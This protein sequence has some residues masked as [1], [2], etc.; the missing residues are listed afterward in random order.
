[1]ISIHVMLYIHLLNWERKYNSMDIKK[2]NKKRIVLREWWLSQQGH[3]CGMSAHDFDEV[4][5]SLYHK[6]SMSMGSSQV[7][8]VLSP[9]C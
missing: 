4:E 1:M 2:R 6:L 3:L 5:M 8:A 7:G 9:P